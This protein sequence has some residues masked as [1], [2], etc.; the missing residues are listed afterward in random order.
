MINIITKREKKIIEKKTRGIG[1][2]QNESNILSKTIR[3]K[4]IEIQSIDAER[5]LIKIAYNQK[6]RAIENKIRKIVL[7][8]TSNVEAIILC[9][10]AIQTN[11]REYNDIDVIVALKKVLKQK[12]KYEVMRKIEK[13]G[14]LQGLKIDIQI[15]SK[16]TIIHQ[17]PYSPSLI[18]QLQ[19]SKI[20]YG[21]ISIPK[22]I[23][24]SSLDLRMKLDWSENIGS[25]ASG[26]YLY[27]AIRNAL[28]VL[29][30]MN[31]KVDNNKLKESVANALGSDLITKLKNNKVSRVEKN[32]VLNYIKTL[33]SYLLDEL[34][35]PQWEKIAIERN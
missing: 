35:N 2:T 17:Y 20:I 1:L 14:S 12:E 18:Y 30:L 4:L 16:E 13:E 26:P 33:V 3:P 31:K 19:D 27:N 11:Y 9:G 32:R 6:G 7:E 10:S 29:L 25:W 34:K 24:L 22:R 8:N 5:L 15:Y 21:K 23:S 28:L